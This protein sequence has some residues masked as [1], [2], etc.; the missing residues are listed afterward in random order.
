LSDFL[1]LPNTSSTETLSKILCFIDSLLC[2]LWW[3]RYAGTCRL[4]NYITSSVA[5][6]KCLEPGLSLTIRYTVLD[7]VLKMSD[8][9]NFCKNIF[10]YSILFC[11]MWK[12]IKFLCCINRYLLWHFI[13]TCESSYCF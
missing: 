1:K 5:M 8:F 11:I 3:H 12:R 10:S 7:S 13:F 9:C 2:D 6:I 4:Q